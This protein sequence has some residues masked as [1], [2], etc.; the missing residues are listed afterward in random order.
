MKNS[1]LL[2][3]AAS[4]VLPLA[5][6]AQDES[7]T[8]QP[9]TYHDDGGWF[10]GGGL[11]PSKVDVDKRYLPSQ[12]YSTQ[13]LMVYTGYKFKPWLSVEGTFYTADNLDSTESN[14]VDAEL[15]G[16]MIAAKFSTALSPSLSIF[17]KLGTNALVYEE[18]YNNANVRLASR[19][20]SW[21]GIDLAAGLGIEYNY[22]SPVSIRLA[23][24]YSDVTL[25]DDREHWRYNRSAD[26]DVEV[27]SLWL[28]FHYQF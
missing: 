19:E 2:A 28:G 10:V 12:D 5:A 17:G 21:S 14:V 27:S 15:Y 1:Y 7:A 23:Y 24:E 18:T 26:I 16:L 11:G 22:N 3:L 25:E 20:D 6:Q 9:A 4:L 8:S 13:A